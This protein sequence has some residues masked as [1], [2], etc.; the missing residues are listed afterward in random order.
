MVNLPPSI[1]IVEVGPRDGLQNETEILTVSTRIEFIK[2]LVD[3]GISRMEAV[4]FVHP[5]RVPQMADAE[6]VIGSLP[7]NDGVT[8]IGLVLNKRGLDR[9]IEAGCKEINYA[10]VASDTFSQKNQGTTIE[11]AIDVYDDIAVTA[12]NANIRCSLTTVSYTHLTLPTNR[13][14]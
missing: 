2:R 3:A 11:Q 8:Y 5:K 9:A 12:K 4:S 10:L 13:E 1:E 14:V 6:A 7:D